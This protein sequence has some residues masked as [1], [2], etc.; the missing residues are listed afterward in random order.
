LRASGSA[1]SAPRS[2]PDAHAH[3]HPRPAPALD[4]A[5]RL[6]PAARRRSPAWIAGG[7]LLV[8]LCALAFAV[9]QTRLGTRQAVLAIAHDVPV[10]QPVTDSDLQVVRLSVDPGLRPVLASAR[11]DIVG[12]PA[13]VPLVAGTLLSDA[14]LGTPS[15]LPPGQAVIGVALKPGQF[16]PGLAPGAR[17]LVADT[18]ADSA[19]AAAQPAGGDAQAQ[20]QGQVETVPAVVTGV[21]APAADAGDPTTVVAL[22][23]AATSAPAL[24]AAGAAGRVV[25]VLVP[26]GSGSRP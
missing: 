8:L 19:A 17:V 21:T 20:G 15:D 13:A 6:A 16:P 10:G 18:G 26:A 23:L 7:V 11:G 1:P 5:L 24:A 9:G 12:R 4:G 3:P 14:E 22:Q 25:V 2:R